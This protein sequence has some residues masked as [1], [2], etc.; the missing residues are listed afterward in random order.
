MLV[1]EC[2]FRE[3]SIK[4]VAILMKKAALIAFLIL[5][6][7]SYSI[8][9]EN[10]ECADPDHGETTHWGGNEMI[11]FKES[12][13]FRS[14]QGVAKI[15]EEPLPNVLVELFDHPDYLLLPYPQSEREKAKQRRIA[16]CKTGD[17]GKFCFSN[18]PKGTYELR[19]SIDSGWDVTHIWIQ[20][21]P[22]NPKGTR[23]GV[24]IQMDVGK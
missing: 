10:C 7:H 6:L 23:A 1:H 17:D 16:V 14:L 3:N 24:D 22:G 11:V 4:N 12:K 18:V 15:A 19:A 13:V 9:R 21:D 8:S 20:V 5:H 2:H